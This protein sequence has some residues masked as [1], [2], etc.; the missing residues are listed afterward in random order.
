VPAC[1][2]S[3]TAPSSGVVATPF[4]VTVN[5]IN[6][7]GTANVTLGSD[8]SF[9]G[10]GMALATDSSA[11]FRGTVPS[12]GTC[13]FTASADNGYPSAPPLTGFKVYSGVLGCN[14]SSTPVFPPVPGPGYFASLP[15]GVSAVTDPGFAAGYRVANDK[16]DPCVLVNFTFTNNILGG[17]STD[18]AGNTL[19]AN[20][21]SYVWDQA[22]QPNAVFVYTLTFVPERVDAITGL[23]TKK[24]KFCTVS[25]P[26]DCTLSANQKVMK[27]C[28][29]TALSSIS[30]P[31]ND[32]ACIAEETWATVA[33][34]D[35]P[36]WTGGGEAPACV[37]TT[38]RIIDA[39]DPPIIRGDF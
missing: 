3:I 17:N 26:T 7:P 32:P 15:L 10:N 8:C 39:R 38:N 14:T 35:C 11:V 9:S 5:L 18:A 6:G 28:I 37:R 4:N 2:M 24:T 34:S 13:S 33:T 31:G 22:V 27:A 19:P 21:A 25:G 1:A 12:T 23:P 20:A 30:I 29:G 16:G 36:A